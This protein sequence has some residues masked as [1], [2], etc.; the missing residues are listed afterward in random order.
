[1]DG[2]WLCMQG[3]DRPKSGKSRKK[4]IK[5]GVIYEG[6]RKR[7]GNKGE[8][9]VINKTTYSTFSGSKDFKI[10]GQA[11][12]A[13]IYNVDEIHKRII[14]GDGAPWIRASTDIEDT[15][16]QLDPFHRSQAIVRSVKDKKEAQ[17]TIRLFNDGKVEEGL[18]YITQM[19]IKYNKDEK[20]FK[21][22]ESLFN[23]FVA[24]KSGL[25]PYKLRKDLEIPEPPI[26]V[27]YRTMGT[28]EHNI[29]D[30]LAK[31]LK[32]H[33]RSW[34]NKG[35]EHMS[36][37]LT[38]NTNNNIGSIIDNT[39]RNIASNQLLEQFE[40]IIVLHPEAVDRHLKK[41]KI[42]KT[43]QGNMPYDGCATTEGRNTIRNLIR[44]RTFS[45]LG[46]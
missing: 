17:T 2:L 6:W 5:L 25:I 10:L 40:D 9:E 41:S 1:M 33:K 18:E 34:S 44:N 45:N 27:E 20:T 21:K 24:N 19:L 16:Y 15:Y 30:I 46:F 13:E 14:N 36:K 26:G 29:C 39:Y 23:Y 42:Y 11:T 8:Y 28:M 12:L 38:E 37:I 3:K 22:L 4:E 7:S 31:R 32:G 43:K 35:A